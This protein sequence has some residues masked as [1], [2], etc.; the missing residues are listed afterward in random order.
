MHQWKEEWPGRPLRLSFSD[1]TLISA[2]RPSV[3]LRD[4]T[5]RRADRLIPAERRRRENRWN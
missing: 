1:T 2:V 4:D 5:I 3:R